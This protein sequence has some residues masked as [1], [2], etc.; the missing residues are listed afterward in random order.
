MS[1]CLPVRQ[2]GGTHAIFSPA[3]LRQV[4]VTPALR[5]CGLLAV[6]LLTACKIEVTVPEGGI[7]S[8]EDYIVNAGQTVVVDG[9]DAFFEQTFVAQAAPGY[10]FT[11]WLAAPAHF[12]GN[13]SAPCSLATGP[14]FEAGPLA[15]LLQADLT[16]FLVPT[17]ECVDESVCGA[18]GTTDIAGRVGGDELAANA[19]VTAT[20]GG[21]TVE[22]LADSLGSF[23]LQLPSDNPDAFLK[24]EATVLDNTGAP[25]TLVSLAGPLGRLGPLQ[26][27]SPVTTAKYALML[28]N[29]G[30]VE[31]ATAEELQAAE[32]HIDISVLLERAILVDGILQGVV[33]LPTGVSTLQA[34]LAS[35]AA[36]ASVLE[37]AQGVLDTAAGLTYLANTEAR[38]A[39]D[40]A[41]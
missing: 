35:D 23:V 6:L 27:V 32:S 14:A 11:Q 9:I 28:E 39:F 22:T 13:T 2:P 20:I 41:T 5:A 24:L 25:R 34:M 10:A 26:P 30:G 3:C 29:N 15:G 7:V 31:P 38:P 33:G 36:V 17:F 12:C 18:A 4:L 21:Q 16:F 1:N 40:P 8:S 19:T 37:A